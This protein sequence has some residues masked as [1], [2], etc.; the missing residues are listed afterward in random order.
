MQGAGPHLASVI[1]RWRVTTDRRHKPCVIFP[2]LP[3]HYFHWFCNSVLFTGV[4]II[5]SNLSLNHEVILCVNGAPFLGRFKL[6]VVPV[7]H[8]LVKFRESTLQNWGA[9]PLWLAY[10]E[11]PLM[12]F[13]GP[14][15]SLR[16]F[17]SRVSRIGRAASSDQP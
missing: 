5:M 14:P 7:W 10:D 4:F 15:Y 16:T 6:S 8:V 1:G 17:L 9:C 12:S 13:R 2:F 11:V 3:P